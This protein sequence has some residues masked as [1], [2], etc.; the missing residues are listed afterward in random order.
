MDAT[1]RTPRLLLRRWR[2]D[3]LDPFAALNA[4]PEVME[5][6]PAPLDR[7]AS[8]AL[9]ARCDSHLAGHGWGLWAV[10]VAEGADAGRFAGFTGLAVPS[11]EAPF[12]PCVE[13]GWRLARWA[14][15]RGYAT[16]AA[17]RALAVGFDDLG[18]PEVVSFTATANTR[19]QAVMRRLGLRR[20][21]ADD[22][23]HPALPAGHPLRRHVLFRL[24]AAEPQRNRNTTAWRTAALSSDGSAAMP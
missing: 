11:F 4:D 6:F 13:V 9:A 21:P 1:L 19:S 10:E 8:D 7:A 16:E 18:L 2:E 23:D 3:D 15:G 20:D 5:H 22:F 24:P 17:R 12:T 14:W